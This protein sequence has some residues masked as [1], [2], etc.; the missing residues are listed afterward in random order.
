[1][2][3]SHPVISLDYHMLYFP[4]I[5]SKVHCVFL[6]KDNHDFSCT[7][8]VSVPVCLDSQSKR[9]SSA[10]INSGLCVGT[11]HMWGCGG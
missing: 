5:G 1:M 8:S 2:Q 4:S 10:E 6:L 3:R 7:D 11:D 9:C